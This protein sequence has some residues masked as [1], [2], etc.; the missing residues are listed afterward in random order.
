MLSKIPHAILNLNR[1]VS[2]HITTNC[3]NTRNVIYKEANKN[4][5]RTTYQIFRNRKGMTQKQLGEL[6]GFKDKTS[7]VRMAQYE[8]EARVPKIDLVKQMSQIF[9]VNTHAL[10]VPDIDTYVGLMHTLFAL[11]DMYGLKVKNVDGQPHLCLD[12]S[13]SAPGSS[14]DQMLRAWMEQ[15]D[16][17]ESGEISKEEYDEWRYKYPELDTYQKR[18]KV[19]SQE[20]SDYLLKELSK[21]EK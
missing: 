12:R 5:N 19:P 8:S 21:K 20:L 17:L 11:E 18:A 14:V 3:G 16:K 1:I 15:A 4:G 6:L 2:F 9:D 7:D 10:T 13:I